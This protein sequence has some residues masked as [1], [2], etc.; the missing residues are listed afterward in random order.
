ML[1]SDKVTKKRPIFLTHEQRRVHVRI[2]DNIAT[3]K[4][5][6]AVTELAAFKPTFKP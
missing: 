1:A 3:P 5:I 6:R 4:L 2:V